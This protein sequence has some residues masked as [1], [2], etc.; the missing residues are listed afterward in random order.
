VPT[1]AS[2]RTKITSIKQI[3]YKFIACVAHKYL[4]VGEI[5]LDWDEML[6]GCQIA[7][8]MFKVSRLLFQNYGIT[9]QQIRKPAETHIETTQTLTINQI[10]FMKNNSII[11]VQDQCA[12]NRCGEAGAASFW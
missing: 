10:D 2:P 4:Q 5:M 8:E 7:V 3:L 11:V 9:R 6:P 12:D 1:A